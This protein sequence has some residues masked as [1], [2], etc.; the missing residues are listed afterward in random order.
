MTDILIAVMA[1]ATV[2]LGALTYV[3]LKR[4]MAALRNK[5]TSARI[6][7]PA[8]RRNSGS[9]RLEVR[10]RTCSTDRGSQKGI[11]GANRTLPTARLHSRPAII[12]SLLSTS[13]RTIHG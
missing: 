9:F 8:C 6:D 10:M 11:H 12:T 5:R 1:I 7:L 4:A 13:R 3:K 2:V